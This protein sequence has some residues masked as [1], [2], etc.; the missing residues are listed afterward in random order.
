MLLAIVSRK[1]VKAPLAGPARNPGIHDSRLSA[2]Q[3]NIDEFRDLS[4]G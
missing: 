2:M 3:R 4:W 1:G